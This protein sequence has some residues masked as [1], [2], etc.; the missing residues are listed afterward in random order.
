MAKVTGGR[1]DHGIR[2]TDDTMEATLTLIEKT[3]FLKTIDILSSVA[4]EALLDLAEYAQELHLAPG[5]VVFEEGDPNKGTFI[6]V[7]GV[8]E[9]RKGKALIRVIESRMAAG[10]LWLGETEPHNY[11]VRA[12]THAHV[13]QIQRRDIDESISDYPEIAVAMVRALSLR[14]HELTER[15]LEL[16]QDLRRLHD[17]AVRGDVQVPDLRVPDTNEPVAPPSTEGVSVLGTG[18][19]LPTE[20]PEADGPKPASNPDAKGAPIEPQR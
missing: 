8:L 7:E 3:A 5:D 2:G 17:A 15:L 19:A 16:E 20:T 10:E 13:L 9:E 11:T 4:T 1:S 18:T 6:V 12:N 14:N